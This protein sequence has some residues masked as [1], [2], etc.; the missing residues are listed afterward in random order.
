MRVEFV[1]PPEK[2]REERFGLL[3]VALFR[4]VRVQAKGDSHGF[5]CRS[6]ANGNQ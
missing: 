4:S 1:G 5:A 2:I 3:D 6:V